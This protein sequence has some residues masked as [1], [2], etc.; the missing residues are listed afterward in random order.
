MHSQILR[1]GRLQICAAPARIK[2][3]GALPAPASQL[4]P[5]PNPSGKLLPEE[6]PP[7]LRAEELPAA[8]MRGEIQNHSVNT[9]TDK[10]A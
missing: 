7:H 9:T 1:Y 10:P 3:A 8:L 2:E 4:N 5:N 6:P